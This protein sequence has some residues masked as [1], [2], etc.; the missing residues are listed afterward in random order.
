MTR[1]ATIISLTLAI[2]A[3]FVVGAASAQSQY[4]YVANGDDTVSVVDTCTGTI[5]A[6]IPV[7]APGKIAITPDGSSAYVTTYPDDVVVIDTST[8]T[9]SA[10]VPVGGGSQGIA[11]TPD[12]SRA[13]VVT[14][15]NILVINTS[16]NAVVDTITDQD[17]DSVWDIAIS[18]D[19]SRAYVTNDGGSGKLFVIDTSTNMRIATVNTGGST[20]AGVAVT[21]D[22]TTVYMCDPATNTVFAV[23]TGTHAVTP[24]PLSQL[25]GGWEVAITPDGRFAY[26]TNSYIGCGN[27]VSVID[28]STNAEVA[29]VP[30]GDCPRG[31]AVAPNGRYAYV[32]N[33]D[34]NT[35][36]V[37]DTSTLMVGTLP[38]FTVPEGIAI[39]SQRGVATIESS[40]AIGGKKDTFNVNE[41][42]YV[43]GSDYDCATT[44]DLYV[45]LDTTWTDGM[46]IPTRVSGTAD[47]V[48]SDISGDIPVGTLIWASSVV[49]KYDI[50]VDVN[51][52]GY[53]DEGIDAL[54]DMDVGDAGLETIPEFSTIA[55]PVASILGLMFFFN[56]HKRRREEN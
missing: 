23:D 20:G 53:Y 55:I 29:V 44:Y 9:V 18:P 14:F 33:A 17:F 51:G 41:A 32:T 48:N 16:T 42:V 10:T 40:D 36:S 54:D 45:V 12:G 5:I 19:G 35:V 21:P 30:V 2:V 27:T 4:A 22:G 38:G 46:T 11:I 8:N 15:P 26:V 39:R 31:V 28:T 7:L 56:Y 13:Y 3:I 49:G 52:N 25:T 50:V 34:D 1:K 43:Y 24:I 6:P 37:I 47:I